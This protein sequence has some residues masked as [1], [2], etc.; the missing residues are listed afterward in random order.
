MNDLNE[1]VIEQAAVERKLSQIDV[2][3]APGPDGLPNW[4][5]RDFCSQLS[6]PPPFEKEWFLIDERKPMWSHA[7]EVKSPTSVENI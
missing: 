6:G 5:L 3:K 1:F 4:I 7:P 2:H